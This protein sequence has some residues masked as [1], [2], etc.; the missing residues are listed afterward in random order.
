M[1]KSPPGITKRRDRSEALDQAGA[2]FED[3]YKKY[4]VLDNDN[5]QK[6][7]ETYLLKSFC[8]K[9]AFRNNLTQQDSGLS[10]LNLSSDSQSPKSDGVTSSGDKYVKQVSFET[11]HMKM[12]AK[13]IAKTPPK[14]TENQTRTKTELPESSLKFNKESIWG[15]NDESPNK[16]ILKSPK[17]SR[18]KNLKVEEKKTSKNKP[19]MTKDDTRI[20]VDNLTESDISE[21]SVDN[22]E[23][24]S[25]QNL[26]TVKE[27]DH[28]PCFDEVEEYLM[29]SQTVITSDEVDHSRE[30]L[31]VVKTLVNRNKELNFICGLSILFQIFMAFNIFGLFFLVHSLHF[32]FH[33]IF[34]SIAMPFLLHFSMFYLVFTIGVSR[35]KKSLMVYNSDITVEI[36]NKRLNRELSYKKLDRYSVG[37]E[38]IFVLLA[39]IIACTPVKFSEDLSHLQVMESLY[40][41]FNV[42][43]SVLHVLFA[44]Y[45][46]KY[47]IMK[48]IIVKAGE[49]STKIF[50]LLSITK[51]TGIKG[52]VNSFDKINHFN[53]TNSVNNDLV[54]ELKKRLYKS[55]KS[56]KL[57]LPSTKTRRRHA[58]LN[59]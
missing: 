24:N 18:L 30:S 34:S 31:M 33:S 55:Y 35:V 59:R 23:E 45:Y 25:A 20:F 16:R 40:I 52:I 29:G 1:L 50:N 49:M 17:N 5:L 32:E 21:E 28:S 36:L 14:F 53:T 38:R 54:M 22:Q 3:L 47:K 46:F 48:E 8:N 51:F 56:R 42:I 39:L 2:V 4:L 13:L 7:A 58:Q 10:E 43:Y 12:G 6:R 27:Y 37:A 15:N 9:S 11:D 26:I 41:S 19:K 57:S 44:F